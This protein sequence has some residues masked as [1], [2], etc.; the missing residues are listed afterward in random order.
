MQKASSRLRAVLHTLGRV[1]L[2]LLL[3]VAAL[4]QL[5]AWTS[6]SWWVPLLQYWPVQYV[7]L[8]AGVWRDALGVWNVVL[9]A[10]LLGLLLAI[11]RA[12]GSGLLRPATVV[13][14]AVLASSLGL[15]SYQVVD[16]RQQGADIGVFAP[17]VP[18]LKGTVAPDRSVTVG[19]VDGTDLD[20]DLYLPDGAGG[21]D[22]VPVV[23]YVH[24]GGFTGGAPAPSPYYPPL[25]ERG[26]A[27]LDVSYRLASPGRQTWDTAVADV[28]C[29]L[30]WVSTEGPGVGLDPER[31]GTMGDS[32]GGQL[33]INAANLGALDELD[34]SCRTRGELPEVS[35]VVAGYPAVDGSAAY[36]QSGLGRAYGDQYVGGPPEEYPERYALTDSV[37]HLSGD[38]PPL[39]IYQG[40]ADH[41]ILPG[42]VR[43]FAR[44]SQEAGTTTRYV[45][46]PGQEH[47]TGGGLGTLSFGDL[48]G[49]DLTTQW[50][51]EHL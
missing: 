28:G 6:P 44:A 24:G 38:G 34:P 31:V 48:V 15:W 22:G 3:A 18:F 51:V 35:A 14:A 41:L 42:P 32:A 36:D 12:R 16:A 40:S 33:A 13:A 10:I 50:F 8:A 11:G 17:V 9:V 29:A 47:T 37:N 43:D 30:T 4:G 7:V 49:R 19:T 20:A 5:V 25:L 1:V 21:G 23:V 39:L 45:E 27:V 2:A 46:L 26:Y